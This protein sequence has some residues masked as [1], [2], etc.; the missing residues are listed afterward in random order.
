MQRG[1]IPFFPVGKTDMW[2]GN[3]LLTSD[4]LKIDFS[5]DVNCAVSCTM[6]HSANIESMSLNILRKYY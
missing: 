6:Y 4:V 3:M 2:I 5:L 1:S